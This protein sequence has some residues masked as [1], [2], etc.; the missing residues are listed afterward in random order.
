MQGQLSWVSDELCVRSN[1]GIIPEVQH[2][3]HKQSGQVLAMCVLLPAY[4]SV[5]IRRSALL[6]GEGWSGTSASFSLLSQVENDQP[7]FSGTLALVPH[8]PRDT[9]S[10]H[11]LERPVFQLLP[12]ASGP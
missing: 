10:P 9:F 5:H 2:Q 3:S 1:I 11:T 8:L 4:I 12:P 7:P 6:S